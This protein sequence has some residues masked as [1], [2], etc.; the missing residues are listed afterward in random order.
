MLNYKLFGFKSFPCENW[1]CALLSWSILRC[2]LHTNIQKKKKSWKLDKENE[3]LKSKKEK[4]EV[5]LNWTY[6]WFCFC[7]LNGLDG[8]KQFKT[9]LGKKTTV[10][11][12]Y[13]WAVSLKYVLKQL[14][15]YLFILQ[16]QRF[17]E[18]HSNF[19]LSF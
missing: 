19:C 4:S 3:I 14:Q 7:M 1:I 6:H 16:L 13:H 15:L 18:F 17:V 9:N 5:L 10:T 11:L 8:F 2:V 12:L